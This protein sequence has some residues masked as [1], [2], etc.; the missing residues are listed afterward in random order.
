MNKTSSKANAR[1]LAALLKEHNCSNIVIAPGSR[2]A[3]L[4]TA[5]SNDAD[6]NCIS[7]PDERVAGFTALGMAIEKKEP[8]ALVCSSGSA[9]VNFYPAITEAFYQNL[10][11][12]VLSAD[13]PKEWIDQGIGQTIRQEGVFGKHIVKSVDLQREP[14]DIISVNY[15]QRQINEA[16]IASERGPVHINVP[17]SEPLYDLVDHEEERIHL[18]KRVK[19]QGILEKDDLEDL[20]ETWNACDK[21]MVLAGQGS[22]DKQLDDALNTLNDKS[23][24]LLLSETVSNIRISK[25]V[26][27]ID[28]LINT[29]NEDQKEEIKPQLLLTIGGEIVSKMVKRLLRDDKIV[30][31]HIGENAEIKDTFL[32]LRR[33]IQVDPTAFVNQLISGAK[34][35]SSTYRDNW[36]DLNKKKSIIHKEYLDTIEFSDMKAM[37]I[38]LKSIPQT[39][40]LHTANSASVRYSQLFDHNAGVEHYSNRGTSGIDGCTSAAIGHA[41]KVSKMVTLISGDV[42]FLY[43]SNAFWNDH[44]P[45]NFRA[46]VLNNSGGNIFRI[47]KGPTIDGNFERYQ[48]TTH[49][50]E[51]AGIAQRFGLHHQKANNESEL[52]DALKDFYAQSDKPKILEVFTPRIESPMVL[53]KYFK[54]LSEAHGGN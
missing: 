2:N 26:E 41:M 31:W 48:E 6:Y 33:L 44:L 27:S 21:I 43:D 24:F 5:F 35:K 47:I 18:I 23:P 54:Y 19:L 49:N 4:I 46:I 53:K 25:K 30:H 36:L 28:R 14:S 32:N 17:F 9:L 12:V 39:S 3:P 8:I 37:E 52:E 45:S 22:P 50:Y 29:I 11:L 20:L 42:A 7:I 15:N 38:I 13:R 10:P 40:I 1:Y 34:T 16:L 51:T